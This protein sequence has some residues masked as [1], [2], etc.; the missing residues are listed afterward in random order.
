MQTV[1][2]WVR[3]FK[4]MW[5]D[6][7]TKF[8]GILKS[9]G[10]HKDLVECRATVSQYRRYQE[11]MTELK[12]KLEETISAEKEKKKLAVKE[13]LAVDGQW[14][15]DHESFCQ[16]RKECPTTAKWI[17]KHDSVEHWMQIDA[18]DTPVLWMN[19]I[20]GAGKM[21]VLSTLC[22]LLI[23]RRQDDTCFCYH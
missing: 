6:F 12:S 7:D 3:I 18:P 5:K 1:A 9:L 2:V 15:R 20:P 17:L 8:S 13:W 22:L 19:A 10:R 11:D 16:V 21:A 4:S 23:C 14:E